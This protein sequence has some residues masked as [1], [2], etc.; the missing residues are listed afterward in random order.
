[1]KYIVLVFIVAIFGILGYQKKR[2]YLNQK[3]TLQSLIDYVIYYD[4]NLSVL[5]N[6]LT[7]INDDYLITHNNKNA[8]IYNIL[9]KNNNIYQFNLKI[10]KNTLFNL[11]QS[12]VIINYLQH[13][14]MSEYENEKNKNKEILEVL[15]NA[16]VKC[17]ENII[18]RGELYFK[19]M[20]AI[21]AIFA[22]LIW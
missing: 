6:N 11:N 5:K 8:N 4:A 14:G 2:F 19:I 13:I 21:G 18:N 22:I 9:L 15:N 3:K 7:Q 10:I 12:S 1:M 20:L 16:L 17:G